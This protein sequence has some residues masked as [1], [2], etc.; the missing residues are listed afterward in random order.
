MNTD[1]SAAP[2]ILCPD[3]WDSA[4]SPCP[5]S[6]NRMGGSQAVCVLGWHCVKEDGEIDLLINMQD[7]AG[8]QDCLHV[9]TSVTD[10]L[11]APICSVISLAEISIYKKPP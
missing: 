2:L 4:R 9:L 3:T 10:L 11:L 1:S 8:L 7:L 5:C 6:V